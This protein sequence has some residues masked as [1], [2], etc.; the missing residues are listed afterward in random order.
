MSVRAPVGPTNIADRECCIG[1]GL[2]AIR[3][4][5]IDGAFLFFNLRYIEKYIASLGSGSTKGAL[6]CGYLKTYPIP[7]PSL[8]EQREIAAVFAALDRKEKAHGRK[9]AALTALFRTLLHQLM[10][11]QLRVHDLNLSE[12]DQEDKAEMPSGST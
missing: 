8:D 1:R 9:H 5:A 12:L 7:M 10:A 4:R 3:P 2:A 6:T 11:A